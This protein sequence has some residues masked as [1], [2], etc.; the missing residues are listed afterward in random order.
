MNSEKIYGNIALTCE[1]YE[2]PITISN[3]FDWDLVSLL[4]I[5]DLNCTMQNSSL[6]GNL[7]V[8]ILK[9]NAQGHIEAAFNDISDFSLIHYKT[10]AEGR[11][12][13]NTHFGLQ[14]DVQFIEVDSKGSN[15]AIGNFFHGGAF[16]AKQSI[17]FPENSLKGQLQASLLEASL[18][19]LEFKNFLI[20]HIFLM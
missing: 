14:N 11:L 16:S 13:L 12:K 15:L 8:D 18:D 3:T 5:S 20:W 10:A 17:Y 6:H 4:K 19:V 1:A 9:K 7:L 2:K